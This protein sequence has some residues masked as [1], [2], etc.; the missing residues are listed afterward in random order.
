MN[1]IESYLQR[2]DGSCFIQRLIR[3]FDEFI[4][5]AAKVIFAHIEPT[6][7][8][9]ETIWIHN[10]VDINAVTLAIVLDFVKGSLARGVNGWNTNIDVVIAGRAALWEIPLSGAGG[11]RIAWSCI[12][13]DPAC[14]V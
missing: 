1:C 13:A 8:G 6:F 11:H 4:P 5:R 14:C 3:Q 9:V 12:T 10:L 2:S 7:A